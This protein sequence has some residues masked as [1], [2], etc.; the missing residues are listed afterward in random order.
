[1]KCQDQSLIPLQLSRRQEKTPILER[2]PLLKGILKG[3]RWVPLSI[4]LITIGQ[5]EVE[6][7]LAPEPMFLTSILYCLPLTH[8]LSSMKEGLVK[9]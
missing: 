9:S 6:F 5:Q 2:H 3:F 7:Y 1:M 8:P 4:I